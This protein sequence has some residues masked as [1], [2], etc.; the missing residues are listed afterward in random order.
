VQAG[1]QLFCLYFSLPREIGEV[2]LF[3]Y[4][5]VSI[6]VGKRLSHELRAKKL[7][8]IPRLTFIA[9]TLSSLSLPSAQGV[10]FVDA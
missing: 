4:K 1:K 6:K 5:K 10:V 2:V 3:I 7:P 9:P 8:N